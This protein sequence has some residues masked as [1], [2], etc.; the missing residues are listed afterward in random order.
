MIREASLALRS[1]AAAALVALAA[2]SA[3]VIPPEALAPPAPVAPFA[4]SAALQAFDAVPEK[5]YRL[6]E[7]DQVTIQVWERPDLSGGQTV[8]PDGII[9]LPVAGSLRI[10]GL[11]REEAAAAVKAA[12]VKFYAD[13]TVTVRV[14][15]Y[16][17]NR[18]FVLG[19]VRTPGVQQFTAPPTLLE[20]LSRAGGLAQDPTASLSHC[21]VIRGRDRMA[22]IDLRRLMEAGDLTLNLGLKPN[23]VVL[24]PEWE[25][26][27]VYVLGQVARPGVQRWMPGMTF[28]DVVARAGG[29][30][31]DALPS[32]VT[33]VR[34]SE[35][36]RFT[37]SLTGLVGGNEAQNVFVRKG[38]IIYVPTNFMAD[39]GYVLEKL[40]PF[41]WVFLAQAVK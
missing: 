26:Q 35:D 6:G 18:V 12:L 1:A 33:V 37:V 9:T 32:K 34:P 24:V 19:R 28:L 5:S 11:T 31:R 15:S 36:L 20:A 17:S 40:Q 7:G 2:C 25:D 3:P 30:T 21:A 13:V 38:D 27:P 29:T 41:G 14:D 4:A 39:I 8:G 22:W 16:V 10:T 23:D